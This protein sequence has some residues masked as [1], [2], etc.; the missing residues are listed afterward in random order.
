M[1][2]EVNKRI[3]AGLMWGWTPGATM[4]TGSYWYGP[5]QLGSN[6][7]ATKDSN[8]VLRLLPFW[9]PASTTFDTVAINTTVASDA[10]GKHRIGIFTPDAFGRPDALV[11]DS[12]QFATDSGTGQ[13]GVSTTFTLAAGMYYLGAAPQGAVVNAAT[14]DYQAGFCHPFITDA[15]ATL[16]TAFNAWQQTGVTGAMPPSLTAGTLPAVSGGPRVM[17]RTA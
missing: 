10:G 5:V 6:Q 8:G 11:L 15:A 7:S 1:L 2:V 14:V 13:K 12:G 4:K 3:Q 9:V 17:L 16:T